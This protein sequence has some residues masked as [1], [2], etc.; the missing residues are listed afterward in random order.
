MMGIA[1]VARFAALRLS[2]LPLLFLYGYQVDNLGT[3][4][5][6][7]KSLQRNG[8]RG[9]SDFEVMCENR[10]T[11]TGATSPKPASRLPGVPS[12]SGGDGRGA[13]EKLAGREAQ[14]K[15]LPT[16]VRSFQ[17]SARTP[18]SR[19]SA[20]APATGFALA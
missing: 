16:K 17:S 18:L 2:G 11:E 19:W 4:N 15:K 14:K 10:G 13:R 1:E 8:Q 9:A 20:Y 7:E 6:R 3:V 12:G 5:W